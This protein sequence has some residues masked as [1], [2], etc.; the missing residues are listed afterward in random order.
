[1]ADLIGD[2]GILDS[3]GLESLAFIYDAYQ[4]LSSKD[5]D[6]IKKSNAYL[7]PWRKAA[8]QRHGSNFLVHCL[9]VFD[10]VGALGLP[11][12]TSKE[13]AFFGFNNQLL[14][15]RVKNAFQA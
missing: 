13:Q 1:V 3:K 9:A 14:S 15:P 4:N 8:N 12:F 2:I 11:I 5:A 6:V 7:D 10:T